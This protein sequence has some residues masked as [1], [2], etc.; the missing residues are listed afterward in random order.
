MT[1]LVD[2]SKPEQGM[3]L[4]ADVRS[5]FE[6]IFNEISA[7]QDAM[8][9]IP[10]PND[11]LTQDDAD[12][13]YLQLTGGIV[14]GTLQINSQGGLSVGPDTMNT[15]NLYPGYDPATNPAVLMVMGAAGFLIMVS[16]PI[17]V[18]HDP[19]GPME[20]ATKQYVD[21]NAGLP[22]TGGILTGPLTI[23]SDTDPTLYLSSTGAWPGVVLDCVAGQGAY[24]YAS[25]N[26]LARWN[27][28]WIGA[29]AE[30]GANAGSDMNISR[31]ADDGSLIDILFTITRATGLI[32][33]LADPID[34]LGIATKQYVDNA[35]LPL[36]TKIAELEA[37]LH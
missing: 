4:T 35:V 25:I 28:N 19:V 13:R 7:L 32:T 15:F 33:I 27:I 36:L 34:P 11:G 5:N 23:N 10:P 22:L 17:A 12:L 3:A 20:I 14:N 24:F 30:T 31:Y 26:G 16:G 37:R 8:A 1:S 29:G 21:N 9:L 6:I 2:F 18:T